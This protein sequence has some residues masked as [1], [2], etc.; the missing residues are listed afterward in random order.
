MS[1]HNQVTI[2]GHKYYRKQIT[3]PDGKRKNLY[4]DTVAELRE[5]EA[6]FRAEMGKKS[7]ACTY[8]VAES[9]ALQLD[10]LRPRVQQATYVGYEEKVRLYIA[11]PPLGDKLINSVTAD[12]IHK[13]LVRVIPQSESTYRGVYMLLRRIFG[14]AKK[15]HLITDD[16][17]DGIS[18]KGGK[19]AA[20]KESLSDKDVSTLLKAVDGLRVETFV[21]LGLYAGLRREEILGL[22]WDCV[23]L[24]TENPYIQVR[25]AW[26]IE[27][28]R[29]VVSERL[30]TPAAKRD[31]PI[32]PVL[33]DHLRAKKAT[34]TGD[35]VV[36]NRDGG[37]LSGSQWRNLWQQVVVRSTAERTYTRYFD[38]KKVPH[39]VTPK[40]GEQAAH[41]PDVVYS[42]DFKVTPHQLRHTYITN[43][44][45][46]GV[47]P[48]TVQYL[49]G[50]DNAKITMDIY[51]KVKYNRPEDIAPQVNKAFGVK[52]EESEM[53]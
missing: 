12:D 53:S 16:P 7:G 50:H 3:C 19:P 4:A 21:R 48:K 24:E 22:Q 6:Q 15:N 28:N 35:Y 13:A 30:K 5:K 2:K 10:L 23:H 40:L 32:P 26:R 29:P 27:H 39:T 34:A 36:A 42:M 44:I 38:R 31:I 45:H 49:A 17:T 14:A 43:L 41:N 8:T 11:T 52:A 51:A 47:D 18:S 46:S 20:E 25:R 33:A 9:A 37:P 1:K